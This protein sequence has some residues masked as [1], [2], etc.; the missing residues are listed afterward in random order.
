[1]FSFSSLS[2]VR[3]AGK[4][5]SRHLIANVPFDT[6][7]LRHLLHPPN[8]PFRD[9]RNNFSHIIVTTNVLPTLNKGET[10]ASETSAGD[11]L[12]HPSFYFLFFPVE[13]RRQEL[14][15]SP[16][17]MSS[18]RRHQSMGASK[19]QNKNPSQN[20]NNHCATLHHHSSSSSSSTGCL[21]YTSTQRQ[22]K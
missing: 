17:S 22:M 10:S 8:G 1:M 11:I 5:I 4:L 12:R 21:L 3:P 18:Y 19:Q 9:I 16:K 15:S 13:E 20:D 6:R 2:L 14:D 7:H